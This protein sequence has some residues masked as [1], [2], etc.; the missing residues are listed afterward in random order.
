MRKALETV[1]FLVVADQ[2]ITQTAAQADVVFAAASFAEKH[3]HV[4]NL[5]GRRQAFAQAVEAPVHVVSDAAILAAIA[6]AMGKPDVLSADPDWLFARLQ[7]AE[8]AAEAEEPLARPKLDQLAS[9]HVDD[10]GRAAQD[11]HRHPGS[12]RYTAAEAPPRTTRASRRM[13][14]QAVA[15]SSRRR[16]V[17][18]GDRRRPRVT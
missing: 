5:E 16:R 8:G 18:L 2:V 13:R 11:V 17:L 3:G 6:Q 12:Q 1:P 4:T 9:P 14:P 10:H 7:A 15:R